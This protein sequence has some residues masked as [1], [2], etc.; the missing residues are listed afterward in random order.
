MIFLLPYTP[1]PQ[2]YPPPPRPGE[3][4]GIVGT[5]LRTQPGLTQTQEH[6]MKVEKHKMSED[7]VSGDDGSGTSV[8][9][10][11]EARV[12]DVTSLLG[13]SVFPYLFFNEAASLFVTAQL[14]VR[15]K[16]LRKALRSKR[17]REARGI[18]MLAMAFV[19][20]A[21]G[22]V[23]NWEKGEDAAIEAAW[24]GHVPAKAVCL[25][26]GWGGYR[27]DKPRAVAIF[28]QQM[29]SR[30]AEAAAEAT[31]RSEVL[32]PWSP[33]YLVRETFCMSRYDLLCDDLL[34]SPL[35]HILPVDWYWALV[36]DLAVLLRQKRNCRMQAKCSRAAFPSSVYCSPRKWCGNLRACAGVSVLLFPK[37]RTGTDW[38][39]EKSMSS[40]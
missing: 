9:E 28:K 40:L 3:R 31:G 32:C 33:W 39:N 6:I 12:Q 19:H 1:H 11:T 27:M 2:E 24:L 35:P 30:A 26:Y 20:G 14:F 21:S 17:K 13:T 7:V 8:T 25:F 38:K 29:L 23:E 37:G 5:L 15:N 22:S 34:R 16:A 18:F 36:L 4:G 10:A